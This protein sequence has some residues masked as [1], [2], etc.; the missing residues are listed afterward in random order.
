MRLDVVRAVA[1]GLDQT[2]A[3]LYV[4]SRIVFGTNFVRCYERS[5]CNSLFEMIT[6]R[7]SA[8]GQLAAYYLRTWS[9]KTMNDHQ[10]S[11]FLEYTRRFEE[12]SSELPMFIRLNDA[13][14]GIKPQDDPDF[15][16][17]FMLRYLNISSEEWFLHEKG[18][19]NDEVWE[20]WKH[21]IEATLTGSKP[22]GEFWW[23]KCRS[24]F[25]KHDGSPTPFVAFVD[26]I[27][28]SQVNYPKSSMAKDHTIKAPDKK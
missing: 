9:I 21:Y 4:E 26:T 2:G 3:P 6:S 10:L 17:S 7:C 23:T 12:I 18:L 1:V 8:F 22:F 11:V 24:N 16:D 13:T 5:I 19:I 25:L 15:L 27:L 20:M 14:S 28:P